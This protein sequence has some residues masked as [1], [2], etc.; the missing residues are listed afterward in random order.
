MGVVPWFFTVELA[1]GSLG[2]VAVNPL[3]ILAQEVGRKHLRELV[4]FDCSLIRQRAGVGACTH[5][6]W[7]PVFGFHGQRPGGARRW[8]GLAGGVKTSR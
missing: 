5:W 1:L 6:A 8:V 7:I 2:I 3:T 4:D